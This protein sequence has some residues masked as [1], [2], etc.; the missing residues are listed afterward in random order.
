MKI[1]LFY[2]SVISDW[3][4][5]NAHF[6]R[7][8]ITSLQLKGH[9]VRV[10][11]PQN[12][13]SLKN[14]VQQEGLKAYDQF[15]AY[16]PFHDSVFYNEE[17]FAPE[18]IIADADMVIVH[19]WTNP[20]VIKKIGDYKAIND[21]F[22][23]LFHDTHHRMIS[24]REN[25]SNLSLKDYDGILAFGDSL[26]SL[27]VESGFTKPVWTWHEA[28]DD[29]VFYPRD[30]ET[31]EGDLV[32]IGNWGEDERTEELTEFIIEPMRKLGIKASFYGV[33]YPDHAIELLEKANIQYKGWLP[34]F[35]VPEIFSKYKVTVH[36]PRRPYVKMLPGI[37]TIRPFE[38]LACGIPLISSL[39]TDSEHLFTPG[40]D[41]LEAANGKE[42][43]K[44]LE[45]VLSDETLSQSLSKHGL[46][47]IR[48][49]HTCNHRVNE[50]L[51]IVN[52]IEKYKQK[53]NTN[54]L[55]ITSKLL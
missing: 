52:T 45:R 28:A 5:G 48:Q 27:Y 9:S 42:M 54:L 4:H 8:I 1:Y 21:H 29:H 18:K 15:Q 33:R 38:A 30:S 35:K 16:Y 24:D 40:K 49:K 19:E 7:G 44:Q 6:L 37:P 26:K 50:L 13:W 32:W 25:M 11:E 55:E 17:K 2:H 41:Y 31:K 36:V 20:Q 39:W 46:N 47:T 43:E 22:T 10:Y 3:N 14:L 23:L 34:N 53:A 12:G 51:G